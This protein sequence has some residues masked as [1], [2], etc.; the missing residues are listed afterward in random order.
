M[1]HSSTVISNEEFENAV[2]N[3]FAC[4]QDRPIYNGSG[5]MEYIDNALKTEYK[6]SMAIS[7]RHKDLKTIYPDE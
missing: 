3:Y 1:S 6:N 4:L 2:R 5:L 7:R